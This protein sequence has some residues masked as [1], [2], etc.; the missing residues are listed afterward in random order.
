MVLVGSSLCI[1][2][3]L[4]QLSIC[5]PLSKPRWSA[6]CGEHQESI[7]RYQEKAGLAGGTEASPLLTA[8]S[9]VCRYSCCGAVPGQLHLD[10]RANGNL[11]FPSGALITKHFVESLAIFS[12]SWS[13]QVDQ[14]EE[15]SS[16][17][18][19]RAR[20]GALHCVCTS[21]FSC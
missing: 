18:L 21:P 9:L 6:A 15:I 19:T 13:L 2:A 11:L 10:R 1:H 3:G 14:W 8:P 16:S 20:Q 17:L 7:R 5:W 12:R 4:L